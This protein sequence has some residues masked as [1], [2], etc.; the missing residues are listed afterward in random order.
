M[1]AWLVRSELGDLYPTYKMLRDAQRTWGSI[2][3]RMPW[4][5]KV[6]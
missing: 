1:K 4:E 6:D 2:Q 3:V 5:I